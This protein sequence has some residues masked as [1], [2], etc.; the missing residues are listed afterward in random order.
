[1]TLFHQCAVT[2][3]V[4][5]TNSAADIYV[6]LYHM[7]GDVCMSASSIRRWRKHFKHG[8]IDIT[9]Q[10]YCRQLRSAM[11][12]CSIKKGDVL[13]RRGPKGDSYR[14]YSAA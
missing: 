6:Q 12:E 14:N 2:E 1:M 11:T 9:D 13:I 5:Q 8:K 10:P 4:K 7:Y 3:L